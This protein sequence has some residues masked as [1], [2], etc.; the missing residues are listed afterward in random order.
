M[1]WN[2][3][4]GIRRDFLLRETL[5]MSQLGRRLMLILMSKTNH[6]KQGTGLIFRLRYVWLLKKLG[7][8]QATLRETNRRWVIHIATIQWIKNKSFAV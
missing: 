8:L 3:R 1:Q 6:Y 7:L 2:A 5:V 4:F